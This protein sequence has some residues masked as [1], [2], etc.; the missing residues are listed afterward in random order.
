VGTAAKFNEP[1]Q[2]AFDEF[3]N[4]YVCDRMNHVIRKITPDG[5]VSTFAGRP[6]QYGYT[7]GALRDARFDRPHG[8]IYNKDIGTFYIADQ[9]NRRIRVITTE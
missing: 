6:N 3:D 4:F 5:V 9:K 8:I 1:H 2:G 7:D